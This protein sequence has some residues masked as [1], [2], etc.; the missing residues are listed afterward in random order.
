LVQ[1]NSGKGERKKE[2]KTLL[3]TDIKRKKGGEGGDLPR[4]E[5]FT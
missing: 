2:K 1:A 5:W 3:S 4:K